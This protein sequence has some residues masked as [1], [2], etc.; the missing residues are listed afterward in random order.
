MF[1]IFATSA[2]WLTMSVAALYVSEINAEKSKFFYGTEIGSGPLFKRMSTFNVCTQIEPNCNTDVVTG[3]KILDFFERT[4]ELGGKKTFLAY[5]NPDQPNIG[6]VDVTDMSNPLP[7]GTIELESPPTA[8]RVI[9]NFAVGA[10]TSTGLGLLVVIDLRSQEIVSQS[11][12]PATAN[13]IDISKVDIELFPIY[14][15][16]STDV[17]SVVIIDI[18]DDATLQNPSSWNFREIVLPELVECRGVR[19]P[20][21]VSIN[22]QNTQAV[23]TLGLGNCNIILD[24]KSG[25]VVKAFDAGSVF[26]DKIDTVTNSLITQTFSGTFLREAV[27]VTWI[28]ETGFFATANGSGNEG[29]GSRGF[30]IFDGDTGEVIYDAGNTIEIGI[31]GIG[32]Y[33]EEQSDKKGNAVENVFYAEAV[34]SSGDT[35]PL[36]FVVS[37]K[38]GVV[39]VYDVAEPRTPIF[40]QTLPVGVSPEGITFI[41]S[42]NAV[43]VANKVDNRP[44]KFRSSISLFKLFENEQVAEYPTLGSV[45]RTIDDVVQDVCIPFSALSSLTATDDENTYFTV[46]DSFYQKSRI[47]KIETATFPALVTSE[48]RILDKAG[49]L[50]DCLQNQLGEGL[51]IDDIVNDDKTVNIDPEGIAFSPQGGFWIASEGKGTVGDVKKP[52]QIPNLLLKTSDNAEITECI[53]LP[54]NFPPQLRFGFEGITQDGDNIVITFQRAWTPD[55]EPR[56]AVYNTSTQSWKYA[57]YPLDTPE[58]QNGGWVGLSDISLIPPKFRMGDGSCFLVLER[59]NQGGPDAVI[60][61]IY[62]INLGD[63]TFEDGVLLEKTLF[64]DV[65]SNLLEAN[66]EVFEKVEGLAI[67]PDGRVWINNDNDGVDG[68]SGEQQLFVVNTL[69]APTMTPSKTPTKSPSKTPTMSPTQVPTAKPTKK[70]KHTKKSRKTK[71][72]KS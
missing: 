19:T 62:E 57:F 24:L 44:G 4:E 53:L 48:F 61:R 21:A 39:F 55:V 18:A 10:T 66:G 5:T 2:F 41:P 9:G 34:L 47:L 7:S 1:Q 46:E 63:Y 26:L 49:V 72:S 60:K 11:L 64:Q 67:S 17:G 14:I 29:E 45:E 3:A 6:F 13:S 25:E 27:G 68:N 31:V 28:R 20:E 30:T 40:L 71:S 35:L 32:H 16:I 38:G 36:L 33:P 50:A 37:E 54:G 70:T 56:I 65:V 58:S 52:F 51:T 59:D 23:V 8:L 12:L 69:I 42:M 43:A 15:V 22:E